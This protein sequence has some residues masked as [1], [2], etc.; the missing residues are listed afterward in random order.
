VERTCSTAGLPR[1][2]LPPLSQCAS[3]G[4]LK[5]TNSGV[6]HTII[7]PSAET[8]ILVTGPAQEEGQSVV[9][10]QESS[11][12]ARSGAARAAEGGRAPGNPSSTHAAFSFCMMAS[13]NATPPSVRPRTRWPP[14]V[15]AWHVKV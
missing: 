3:L 9:T 15:C 13:Y 10:Q 2:L 14:L 8:S 6:V 5:K 11:G 12:E 7:E 4:Q 1:P